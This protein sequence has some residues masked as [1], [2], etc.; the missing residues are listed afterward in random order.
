MPQGTQI[1]LNQR[2]SRTPLS[3]NF[4]IAPFDDG[5]QISIRRVPFGSKGSNR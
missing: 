3:A 2:V 5:A 4:R 1:P